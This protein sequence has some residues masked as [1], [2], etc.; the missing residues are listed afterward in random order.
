MGIDGVGGGSPPGIGGP[1]LGPATSDAKFE[2]DGVDL[3]A[4][5]TEGTEGASELS[6][7]DSG[8]MSVEA[9]L[10]GR[11]DVAVAHLQGQLAPQ[12]LAIIKAQ[13]VEQMK[14]D[15]AISRLV[16]RATG[17]SQNALNRESE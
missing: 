9:Y 1:K 10:D 14:A 2:V 12:R 17:V 13:L 15:P 5:A 7:L 16:Q 3:K 11:A 8:E 4:A 6:K